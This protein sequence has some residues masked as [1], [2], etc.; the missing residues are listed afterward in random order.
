MDLDPGKTLNLALSNEVIFF[1]HHFEFANKTVRFPRK[2]TWRSA[3]CVG[4]GQV[5]SRHLRALVIASLTRIIGD[6]LMGC[7]RSPY[8][9]IIHRLFAALNTHARVRLS[10]DT[11]R[12]AR[13]TLH[14]RVTYSFDISCPD[15][16]LP[17]RNR[18][19][20]FCCACTRGCLIYPVRE[21]S[22]PV[23]VYAGCILT[24]C[25]HFVFL[26][27]GTSE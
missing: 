25:Y 15:M 22:P 17:L 23:L 12:R 27:L 5:T 21:D 8:S 2:F 7:S 26:A 9:F 24:R 1:L 18:R 20:S 3:Y 19:I 10:V 11:N 13:S 6:R 4:P 16:M 14:S